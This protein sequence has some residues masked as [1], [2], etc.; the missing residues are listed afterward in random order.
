[1]T[2]DYNSE[3]ECDLHC[4]GICLERC[5]QV[6]EAFRV[7]HDESDVVFV[8]KDC[9]TVVILLSDAIRQLLNRVFWSFN[10]NKSHLLRNLIEEAGARY[11]FTIAQGFGKE[12]I[13][14]I[15]YN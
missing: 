12:N 5:F 10:D 7:D 8:S 14:V 13:L 11:A 9:H 6:G 3:I 4:G 1:M 15:T 2:L